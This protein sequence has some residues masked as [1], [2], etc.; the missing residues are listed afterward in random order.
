MRL[1][2]ARNAVECDRSRKE[3]PVPAR[4]PFSQ[5]NGFLDDRAS[6]FWTKIALDGKVDLH[7]ERSFQRLPERAPFKERPAWCEID[8]EVEVAVRSRLPA[9]DR[10]E[11]ANVAGA[12]RRGDL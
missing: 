9:R 10:P 4:D 1:A 12:E 11:D 7:A 6:D 5:G 2:L 8:Q 3:R